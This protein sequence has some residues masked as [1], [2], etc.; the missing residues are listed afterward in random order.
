MQEAEGDVRRRVDAEV[1]ADLLGQMDRYGSRYRLAVAVLAILTLLGIAATIVRLVGTEGRIA[2]GY[3]AATFA[4][5]L[6]TVQSAPLVIFA[7]R[8]AKADWR[9]PLARAVEMLAVGQKLK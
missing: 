7:L 1:V 5:L 3:Y 4:F 2:L 6:S 9:R 8:L